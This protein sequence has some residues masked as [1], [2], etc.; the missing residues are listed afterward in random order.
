MGAIARRLATAGEPYHLVEGSWYGNDTC[1]RMVLDLNRILFYGR[2]DGSMGDTPR[3]RILSLTDAVVCGEGEGP[4]YPASII[5]G[6]VTFSCSA[7]AAERVHAALLRLDPER[8]PLIRESGGTFRLPLSG[9]TAE[10][11]RVFLNGRRWTLAEIAADHGSMPGRRRAGQVTSNCRQR[12]SPS[13]LTA[14]SFSF[15]G[16]RGVHGPYP[17]PFAAQS[18]Q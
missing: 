5:A 8:I 15:P 14:D 3:Q 7:P 9:L 6:A 18:P 12:P 2:P 4:L 13:R 10:G 1:W 16:E 11:P 17:P